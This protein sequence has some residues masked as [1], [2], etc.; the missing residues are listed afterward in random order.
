M[1]F[2]TGNYFF[3]LATWI[4]YQVSIQADPAVVLEKVRRAL[5]DA[6]AHSPELDGQSGYTASAS[7]DTRAEP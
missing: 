5:L 6:A 1:E 3:D 2:G 4:E 7:N